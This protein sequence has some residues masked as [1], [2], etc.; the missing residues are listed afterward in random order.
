MNETLKT[1]LE[2]TFWLLI[3]LVIGYLVNSLRTGNIA[4]T[5]KKLLRISGEVNRPGETW[6]KFITANPQL[7]DESELVSCGYVF[8]YR[9]AGEL[10]STLNKLY[11]PNLQIKT[12]MSKVSFSYTYGDLSSNLILIGGP[13]HNSVT[14]EFLA[15]MGDT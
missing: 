2:E 14:R 9:G 5:N 6:L 12:A 3:P 4:N 11:G 1:I 8:E 7:A 13:F 10:G 15:R